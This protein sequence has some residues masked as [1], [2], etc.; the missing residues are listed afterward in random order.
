MRD[1][2]FAT[3]HSDPS[4]LAHRSPRAPAAL[5]AFS[6]ETGG[7]VLNDLHSALNPTRVH[8]VV[9]VASA[10]DVRDAVQVAGRE[11]RVV[12][13]MGGRHAMGAQQFATGGVAIDTRSLCGI[14]GLD[15]E[16]GLVTVDAGVQW[17]ELVAYLVTR[18]G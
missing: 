2:P 13:I 11:G 17:P 15:A 10:A 12:S 14:R 3:R 1:R 7:L 6:A 4:M 9:P 5:T 16:S 8:S 18:T